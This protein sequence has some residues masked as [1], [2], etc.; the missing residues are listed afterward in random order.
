MAKLRG[1]VLAGVLGAVLF[2]ASPASAE[3]VRAHH[4]VAVTVG[5]ASAALVP[6]Q[7]TP[8]PGPVLDPAQTDKANTEKT[9]NKL[10]AGVVAVA[11]LGIVI[12]GRRIR[13][14]KAK[15]S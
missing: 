10:V 2:T 5:H 12:W 4:T 1:L 11:L 8:N 6:V 9:R 13:S 3:P 7:A 15:S 14:K